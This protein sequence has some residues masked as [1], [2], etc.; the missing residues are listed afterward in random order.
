MVWNPAILGRI[1]KVEVSL[2]DSPLQPDPID[3]EGGVAMAIGAKQ[4]GVYQD[5][6]GMLGVTSWFDGWG[7]AQEKNR[8]IAAGYG[9]PV[10]RE[11]SLG[12][13]VRHNRRSNKYGTEF[14]WSLDV[15]M[16][17][18]YKLK[19]L[20]KQ[21]SIGAAINK[22]QIKQ[23]EDQKDFFVAPR[24]GI[25]YHL[26]SDRIFSCDIAYR[27]DVE[28]PRYDRFRAYIGAE[29]WLFNK[30]VGIRVGYTGITNYDRF[31]DGEWS[32]GV[33]LRTELGEIS[34]AYVNGP[35]IEPGRHFISA[36]LR[37]GEAD[38]E[39]TEISE[40]TEEV[41]APKPILM[42]EKVS[43]SDIESVPEVNIPHEAFS[44][45]G[46][47]IKDEIPIELSIGEDQSW[48]LKIKNGYDENVKTFTGTGIPVEPISWDGKDSEGNVVR[49]GTYVA[50][51]TLPEQIKTFRNTIIVDTTSPN[52][53]ISTEPLLIISQAKRE[54]TS[55]ILL[56]VPRIHV[57]LSDKNDIVRWTL[58][59]SD[60]SGNVLRKFDGENNPKD[61][62]VWNNWE[63]KIVVRDEPQQFSCNMTVE[64]IAGNGTKADTTLSAL[65]ISQVSGRRNE[66]GVVISLSS[67]TFDTNKYEVKSE[68]HDALQEVAEVI[69]AY[70]KTKVQ[71]EGHTDDVGDDSYNLELS[72]KRANSVMTYLVD[73]FGIE[74]ARLTAMGYGEEKPI[75]SNQT[76]EGR[77][78][79]RRVDIVLLTVD[80]QE[81]E[82]VKEPKGKKGEGQKTNRKPE[83]KG[84]RSVNGKYVVQVGS[85]R[86]EI[87]AETVVKMVEHMK[88]NYR[89]WISEVLTHGS[90]WY[91]VMVGKFP[92][93]ASAQ[94]VTDLIKEELDLEPAVMPSEKSTTPP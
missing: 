69:Q 46:D 82:E 6:V 44:P 73:N 47:G 35:L 83:I 27:D 3:R 43:K 34:Y 59:I 37:W 88:L 40:E 93:K 61:E 65:N 31:A 84:Q 28:I 11:L 15:G 26:D 38:T 80:A 36:T 56:N 86:Q 92:D 75:A 54:Y 76:T 9:L 77:Q 58:E 48:T 14:D 85:F 66:R 87:N 20:G 91:R 1:D 12:M 24:L 67:I 94:K 8:V 2:F 68:Y 7:N 60:D 21:F 33:S 22:I 49:E 78:K 57:R 25:A 71:I 29:R 90:T 42:P 55:E 41:A 23:E 64:D 52:L 72:K 30:I 89:V 81:P 51:L 79:N 63:E 19:Q 5:D 53:S 32:R 16:L 62:I 17:Y 39:D 45:N 4:I 50:L 70:P 10:N 13:A 74:P 18:S